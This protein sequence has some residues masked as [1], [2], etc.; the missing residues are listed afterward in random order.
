MFKRREVWTKLIPTRFAVLRTSF[1]SLK[2]FKMKASLI[3]LWRDAMKF[4]VSGYLLPKR[5]RNC[6][7]L[8]VTSIREKA[9][10]DSRRLMRPIVDLTGKQFGRL[11]VQRRTADKDFHACWECLCECGNTKQPCG[12]DLRLGRIRSCGCL[13][14][15]LSSARFATNN[16]RPPQ[17]RKKTIQRGTWH[18]VFVFRGLVK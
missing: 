1:V 15:D 4:S 14:R 18:R 3:L 2:A 11:T 8:A 6:D 16:P 9:V 10:T 7:G 5:R 13:A 17:P 12:T